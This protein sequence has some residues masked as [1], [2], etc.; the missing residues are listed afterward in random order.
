MK[1]KVKDPVQVTVDK[2][3]HYTPFPKQE[4][5]TLIGGMVLG[6]SVMLGGG[7]VGSFNEAEE[8]GGAIFIAGLAIYG[9][10]LA[11]VSIVHGVWE[12]KESIIK[13]VVKAL[14]HD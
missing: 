13:G 5:L 14:K 6:A 11:G 4:S 7:I 8:I 1:S 12:M 2:V 9:I 3:K 10:C